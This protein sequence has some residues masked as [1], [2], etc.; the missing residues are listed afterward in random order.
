MFTFP[1]AQGLALALTVPMPISA[2]GSGAT[3][4]VR[5]SPR[6]LRDAL[7]LARF[8]PAAKTITFADSGPPKWRALLVRHRKQAAAAKSAWNALVAQLEPLTDEEK[9][10]RVNEVVNSARY[11]S[12]RSNWGV[13]DYWET[14]QEL[15]SRGGDCEDF[16]IAKY[17]LLRDIGIEPARMQLVISKDHAFL[18][19]ATTSGP[20]V[21][22][23]R[24]DKI[25]PLERRQLKRVQF[26]M[27]ETSWSAWLQ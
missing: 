16:A 1:L 9:L 22:D 10:E 15:F 12:D 14:P 19:V 26:T 2:T 7:Q 11:A 13:A 25:T 18:V 4:Q 8:D 17:L 24:R 21:L 5:E 27:N 3:L 20:V 23:N 6:P